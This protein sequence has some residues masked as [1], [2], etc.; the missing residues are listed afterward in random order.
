M[1]AAVL[2][3]SF[4]TSAGAT[5]VVGVGNSA[6]DNRCTNQGGPPAS[7]ATAYAAGVVSALTAAVP[8]GVPTNHCG[9]LG[10]PL[11]DQEVNNVVECGGGIGSPQCAGNNVQTGGSFGGGTVSG[12]GALG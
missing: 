6:H 7:A 1:S 4:A 3:V 5:D 2:P 8:P 10:A 9:G 12:G 11:I